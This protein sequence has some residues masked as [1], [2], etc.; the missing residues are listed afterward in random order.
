MLWFEFGESCSWVSIG[1]QRYF[2]VKDI[3]R[4]HLQMFSF[5]GNPSRLRRTAKKAAE[6]SAKLLKCEIEKWKDFAVFPSKDNDRNEEGCR[7]AHSRR[8]YQHQ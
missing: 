4:R 3:R 1:A 6:E 2:I 8:G 5:T 7:D